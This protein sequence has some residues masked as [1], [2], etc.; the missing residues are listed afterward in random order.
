MPRSLQVRDVPD[1]IHAELRARAALQGM[2]LSEYVL[3]V[4]SEV[5]SRPP[6]AEVLERAANRGGGAS[7]EDIVALIRRARDA[8]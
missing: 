4:L 7:R 3:G 1:D 5:A 2:S 8:Q 6:V